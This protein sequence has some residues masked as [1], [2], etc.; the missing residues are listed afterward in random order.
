MADAL[1]AAGGTKDSRPRVQSASRAVGILLEIA[2]SEN[3]LTTRE[4]SEQVGIGRQATYH[5]LHTL[6]EAGMLTRTEGNRYVMGLRVGALAEGFARHLAPGERLGPIVREVAQQTGE[7]C[8]ASGW[9]GD[10]IAV[11]IVARSSNP[12][13]V[14]EVPQGHVADAHARAAGKLLLAFATPAVREQYLEIHPLTKRTEETITDPDALETEFDRIREQGFAEDD[15]EYSP[16]VCC[17]AVPLDH[18]LTPFALTISAPRDRFLANRDSYLS[19]LT[20]VA[21]AG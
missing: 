13:G 14:Q 6:T 18:G 1:L 3:G 20:S 15:Q 7:T 17:L 5:L 16:G 11:L 10:E 8:Y 12:L 9:W 4:I 21:N 2:Q 19:Q